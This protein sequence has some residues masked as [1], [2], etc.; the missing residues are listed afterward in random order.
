MLLS[1]LKVDEERR[2]VY[3]RAATSEPDRSGEMLDYATAK[4]AFEEWSRGIEEASGGLSKGNLRVQH[5]PKSVAGKIVD[6]S[7][8]DA[9]EAVDVVCKVVSDEA[10]KMC[11]EGCF[12][13]LSIGGGYARKWKD[14]STGLTKY[15][16]RLTEISLVDNPCIPGARIIRLEK[17]DGAVADLLLKG[18]ARSFDEILPLPA[19]RSFEEVLKAAPRPRTFEDVLR[20]GG[21]AICAARPLH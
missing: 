11:L 2:L 14:E 20:K 7:F 3:A 21:T 6:M 5:D 13:G 12:T 10:W 19:F 18:R 1:L 8:D 4:P 9:N 17:A 16:P 15:T